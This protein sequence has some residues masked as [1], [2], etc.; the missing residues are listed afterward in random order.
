M[1]NVQVCLVSDQPIPNLTTIV[2]FQPDLVILLY[3][4]DRKPQKDRLE[5][6]VGERGIRV[7]ARLILPYGLAKGGWGTLVSCVSC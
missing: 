7:E 3:T 4:E 5:R 2:Q 1:L 6:V